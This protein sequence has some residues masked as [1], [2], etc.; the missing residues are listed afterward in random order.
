MLRS[1]PV[2]F[3][4]AAAPLFAAPAPFP[5][6]K[7]APPAGYTVHFRPLGGPDQVIGGRRADSE[8]VL[9]AVAA[10]KVRP[11]DLRRMSV[12]VV[13]PGEGGGPRVLPVD[14]AAICLRGDASTNYQLLPGDQLF[15]QA[16]P[17]E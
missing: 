5:K 12:W 1:A 4:I 10:L 9:D 7:K 3:A 2:L 16:R 14:W 15:L 8:T 13:R 11:S 17:A 6:A